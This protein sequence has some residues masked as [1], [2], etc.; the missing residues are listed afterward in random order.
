MLSACSLV[1]P[2]SPNSIP[3]T[4]STSNLNNSNSIG[5]RKKKKK[6]KKT[7][8]E[9]G[10]N[11]YSNTNNMSQTFTDSS[12]S[13]SFGDTYIDNQPFTLG[14]VLYRYESQEKDELTIEVGQELRLLGE[15][16]GG[17]W[18]LAAVWRSEGEREE[19]RGRDGT[20]GGIGGSNQSAPKG[21]D[22]KRSGE[23]QGRWEVGKNINIYAA[24]SIFFLISA[25]FFIFT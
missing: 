6:K 19:G 21:D 7:L 20:Y 18:L 16:E 3:S 8:E 10:S 13:T 9:N 2:Q 22:I 5:S 24:P 1:T 11:N 12:K 15:A 25:N 4:T 17:Q 23:G 14:H